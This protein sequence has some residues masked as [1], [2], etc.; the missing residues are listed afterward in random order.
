MRYALAAFGVGRIGPGS[1]R[2]RGDQDRGDQDR[3]DQ[4]RGRRGVTKYAIQFRA[5]CS[6]GL[7][8]VFPVQPN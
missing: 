8:E 2:H 7:R 1:Q 4:G 3:G 6:R 5:P